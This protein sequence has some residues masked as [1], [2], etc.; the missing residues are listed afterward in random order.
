VE[1]AGVCMVHKFIRY[2]QLQLSSM[3]SVLAVL[4][5]LQKY[6]TTKVIKMRHRSQNKTSLKKNNFEVTFKTWRWCI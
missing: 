5:M 1:S 4:Q 2:R 3:T 6:E